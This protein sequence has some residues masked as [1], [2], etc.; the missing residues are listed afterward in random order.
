M[1]IACIAIIDS[2]DKL[3]FIDYY[4]NNEDQVHFKF[5]TYTALQLINP[6]L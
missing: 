4:I 6:A 5:Q 3:S 2:Q 1:S